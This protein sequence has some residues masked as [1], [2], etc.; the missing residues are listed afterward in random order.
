MPLGRH[1]E[2]ERSAARWARLAMLWGGPAQALA[3]F[4]SAL[5]LR[6]FA[7]D[8][9]RALESDGEVR[10]LADS[11][12]AG[13]N[14]LNQ[15][16]SL[17]FLAAGVLFLF[18]FYRSCTLAREAGLPAR[19]STGLALASWIIPVINWWW[20]YQSTVDTLPRHHPGQ[21]QVLRWWLLWIGASSASL[22]VAVAAFFSVG[23]MWIVAAAGVG[24]S[25]AAA[26]AA[27]DVIALVVSAHG[28]LVH[29]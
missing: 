16:A 27:R 19:R 20:P 29:R 1:L 7:D 28:E 10:G 26:F 24:L 23:A 4:T 14:L 8:F 22:L 21:P 9:R 11:G 2:S 13:L 6:D 25:L 17:A 3:T 12:G 15:L 5:L 18:W